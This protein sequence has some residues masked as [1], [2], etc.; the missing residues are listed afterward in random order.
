MLQLSDSALISACSLFFILFFPKGLRSIHRG[1]ANEN[2]KIVW[3]E[4]E[5][6]SS[7]IIHH[8]HIPIPFPPTTPTTSAVD[9]DVQ[10][11]CYQYL[12]FFSPFN[13]SFV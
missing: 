6:L 13:L 9:V 1:V 8:V 2:M 3:W 10:K 7:S 4:P 12:H 5:P 11:V